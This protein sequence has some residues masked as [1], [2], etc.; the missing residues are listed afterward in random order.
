MLK[1]ETNMSQEEVLDEKHDTGS[2]NPTL[3]G[4][5][6]E[7][8]GQLTDT[9]LVDSKS[10]MMDGMMSM[11]ASMPKDK[12]SSMFDQV[13]A[14]FGHWADSIPDDAAAKNAATIAAK[15][16]AGSMKE[17]ITEMF[18]GE[19]LSEEFK[20]KA[21]VLF[22]AAVNAK[23]TTVTQELEEQFEESLTEELSYFT[24]EVSDKLDSYLDYVVE[25]WMVENEVAIESTLRN[26]VN[27]DFIH[28]LKGLF[29]DNYIEMPEDK[30]DIVEGLAEKVEHL[31]DRLNDS[32][33][34][35]TELKNVLS[36]SV[37]NQ[38]IDDVSSDLTLTQQDKFL[39]FA[40]GIEFDGDVEEYRKKLDIIKENYFGNQTKFSSSNLEEEVLEEEDTTLNE[41][42][43]HPSMQKYVSALQRSVKT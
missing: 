1:G 35:N 40:E 16:S 29:E 21:T 14:Q 8:K 12:V 34:E 27:E 11:M 36:E 2:L 10:S 5:T 31:E 18:S 17:D 13:M 30:V 19:D 22:E 6:I 33:N 39:S 15:P 3:A 37:K 9:K 28:G 26:E 43:V 24:E 23:V 38:A 25:N 42:S 4:K 20:E 41:S 7:A 32:I